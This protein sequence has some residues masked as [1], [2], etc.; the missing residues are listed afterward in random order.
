MSYRLEVD[1]C[2]PDGVKRI[3]HG[4][5]TKA[6]DQLRAVWQQNSD[7]D[8]F[9]E[10]VD[11][12]T[13]DARNRFKR[14]RAILRL[15]RDEIG[16]EVYQTENV[17]YRD[18]GQLLSPLRDSCVIVETFDELSDY[19]SDQLYKGTFADIRQNLAAQHVSKRK[20]IF[21]DKEVIREVIATIELAQQRIDE[22]PIHRDDFEALHDGLRRTYKRGYK[23]MQDAYADPTPARFHEWRK[24]MKYHWYHM[25]IL[26]PLWPNVLDEVAGEVHKAANY[27]GDAHDLAELQKAVVE[28]PSFA[29]DESEG[30]ALIGLLEQRRRELEQAAKP[31]GARIYVESPKRFMQ[32]M[33]GYWCALCDTGEL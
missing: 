1:E 9:V 21:E 22:W 30:Q 18:A 24:R 16:E 4:Q 26:K 20:E 23:Q 12:A 29:G 5:V 15:V 8:R 13:H 33:S 7:Y 19:F 17:C 32:R 25:R 2:V 6:L 27:L 10:I 31:L 3:V 28:L 14:I 11:E